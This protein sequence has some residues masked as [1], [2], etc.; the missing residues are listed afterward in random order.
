M[1]SAALGVAVLYPVRRPE[2]YAK[3]NEVKKKK[4]KS[5]R[6]FNLGNFQPRPSNWKTVYNTALPITT[7]FTTSELH[8]QDNH[9]LHSQ[10]LPIPEQVSYTNKIIISYIASHY[11]F[12][13]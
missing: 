1:V 8:Q 9:I 6:R 10:S 11:Q 12:H 3:D 2:F 7:N 5:R 13:V 4:K